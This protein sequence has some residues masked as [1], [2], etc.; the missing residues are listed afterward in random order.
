MPDPAPSKLAK[1]T[2][3][4]LKELKRP[5]ILN[6]H[7]ENLQQI[8]EGN[9]FKPDSTTEQL[10]QQLRQK[11]CS[12]ARRSGHVY[13]R[14]FLAYNLILTTYIAFLGKEY[15]Y[16]YF[17]NYLEYRYDDEKK[18]LKKSETDNVIPITNQLST[19]QDKYKSSE[20]C[21]AI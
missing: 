13:T 7:A 3:N 17:K 6:Q 9:Y 12:T 2:L 16:K 20:Y 19:R 1:D 10:C 21:L 15:N 8:A 18:P 14:Q 5:Q 11:L 4:R